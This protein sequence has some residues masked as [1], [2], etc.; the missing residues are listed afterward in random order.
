MKNCGIRSKKHGIRA[1]KQLNQNG[2]SHLDPSAIGKGP[3]DREQSLTK[4]KFQIK[5]NSDQHL[6]TFRGLQGRCHWKRILGTWKEG[7]EV[8]IKCFNDIHVKIY[9]LDLSDID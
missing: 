6:R 3:I 8:N 5:N 9:D 2:G 1:N 4:W 7:N